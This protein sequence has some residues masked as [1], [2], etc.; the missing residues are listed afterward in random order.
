MRFS[1][2]WL[3][4]GRNRAPELAATVARVSIEV[5]D[6][7]VT[8]LRIDGEE[9][10]RRHVVMPAYVLAEGLVQRWWTLMGARGRAVRL[11]NIRQGFAVPDVVLTPDAEQIEVEARSF[12]Y[13]NPAVAFI[14]AARETVGR[15]AFRAELAGFAHGVLAR[16]REMDIA[17]SPL[18]DYWRSIRTS[19]QNAQEHELCLA[20][21]ALGLDP[22]AMDERDAN[23]IERSAR[24]FRGEQLREFLSGVAG[25]AAEEA[26]SWVT[27][28]EGRLDARI[29]L[30][31]LDLVGRKVRRRMRGPGPGPGFREAAFAPWNV[32]YEAART[33]RSAIDQSPT[34]RFK[35][36]AALARKFGSA[37]FAVARGNVQGLRA[38]VRPSPRRTGI[39]VGGDRPEP[40]KL[41][42]LARAIGD[43][44][45]FGAAERAAI[46][47]NET[48]RQAVGRAFAAELLAPA[49]F[50]IDRYRSGW[51]PEDIALECGVSDWVVQHQIENHPEP[52]AA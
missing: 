15:D 43:S 35:T 1:A 9:R 25:S 37:D 26:L 29:A 6:V 46:T 14:N 13:G 2:D 19:E 42:A 44:I 16:L 23:L 7:N 21:G 22:Y 33:T 20:A 12:A 18:A 51:K 41:F 32:G 52:A 49:A 3:A 40:S 5:G 50:V 31:E 47:D 34:E 8:E 28:E 11:R 30:P 27:G 17:D 45:V 39:L 4:K 38:V 48:R 36:V 24:V 10:V